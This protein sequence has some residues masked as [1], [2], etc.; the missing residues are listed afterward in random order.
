M[1]RYSVGPSVAVPGEGKEMVSAGDGMSRLGI[2][3]FYDSEGVVDD[4]V[5]R[6]LEGIRPSLTDLVVVSNG[7]LSEE[8]ISRLLPF[9]DEI[10]VRENRGFDV[11][12]YRYAMDSIGW[13][14]LRSYDEVILM[15]STIMGPVHPFEEMFEEMESREVD[16]WGITAYHAEEHDP[17]GMLPD[18]RIP[19]HLQSHFMAF[20]NSM[21][22]SREFEEYWSN[23]PMI[24]NSAEAI[25]LHEAT[26]T[27]KFQ[28]MG[29]E[30]GVYVDTEDLEETTGHPLSFC[31]REL[32][33]KRKSP[34]FERQSFSVDYGSLLDQ[35]VGSATRSLYEY[36][37]EHSDYDTDLVWR[38]VLRTSNLADL[39]RSLHLNYV[40]PTDV[41]QPRP[42]WFPRLA[43]V[44]HVY[45]VELYDGM[46]EYIRSMP[47][48][49]SII[50]TTDS[51]EKAEALARK[52]SGLPYSV[53][54]RV[55]ENRGRD[56]SGLLVGARDVLDRFD[57]VCFI[58]DKR[59][60]QLVPY[61]KGAGFA[62]KCFENLLATPN[63]VANVLGLFATEA[64]LG[65]LMP[66][67][68]NHSDYFTTHVAA[69]GP[70]FENTVT[71]LHELGV[72]VALSPDKPPISPLGTMF[73][74]R[75]KALQPLLEREWVYE[76]FP[77]EPNGVDGTFL[78]AIERAYSYVGQSVG[79]Y[80]AWL[81]S[82]RFA[83][84]E[85]T[86]LQF[87]TAEMAK[88]ASTPVALA[89]LEGMTA[90][91]RDAP[92]RGE[93]VE[94]QHRVV[95]LERELYQARLDASLRHRV[96]QVIKKA[97][98]DTLHP[99]VRAAV[100]ELKGSKP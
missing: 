55:V 46:L 61:S 42:E 60:T 2:Y 20:R 11:W 88:A 92:T 25:A 95:K 23:I 84:V 67:P 32:V 29:F 51:Q 24:N 26:F 17:F 3:F 58:H 76:D 48:G 72:D 45:Y 37:R 59:V 98:P 40:L 71:L 77:E 10:I 34:I 21:V 28:K 64:R 79:Y 15:N 78:H 87:Q 39:V 73:W 8:A 36:L 80:S 93:L 75:P 35:S 62:E 43:L 66:S 65:M 70:N 63:F 12:A 47:E 9:T 14:R 30:A 41:K 81:Y 54:V 13:E 97:V 89:D 31:P 100:N 6:F 90:Q 19:W 57:L 99:R 69:W 82:D 22:A 16:F 27:E 56:V 91:L 38:N 5:Q 94:Q 44:A 83:A 86:N 85:L 18:G 4:Y 96:K 50:L 74:F 53:E 33:E 1:E 52:S 49:A 68:P 7:D